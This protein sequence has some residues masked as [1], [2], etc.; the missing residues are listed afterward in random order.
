MGAASSGHQFKAARNLLQPR[1]QSEIP[2]RNPIGGTIPRWV[3]GGIA[4][5]ATNSLP[6]KR[7]S[8]SWPEPWSRQVCPPITW[9]SALIV[10][11]P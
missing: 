4:K 5:P 1:M 9:A 11:M 8:R 6:V 3:S 10:A 7:K 2:R